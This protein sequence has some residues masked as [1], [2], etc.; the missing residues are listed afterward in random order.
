MRSPSSIRERA[1]L[2]LALAGCAAP[3]EPDVITLEQPLVARL[4][5][6]SWQALPDRPREP[7]PPPR[8]EVIEPAPDEDRRA[9]PYEVVAHEFPAISSDG[10]QLVDVAFE[11]HDPYADD[12]MGRYLQ[13]IVLEPDRQ[14]VELV[15]DHSQERPWE[16]PSACEKG[17]ARTRRTVAR[18]NRELARTSWRTLSKLE[19]HDATD[20][21]AWSPEQEALR[22]E[23]ETE[24]L[25][26]PI[27]ERP[28]EMLF[29]DGELVFRVR[30]GEEFLRE[31]HPDW[32]NKNS[33]YCSELPVF[34]PVMIDRTSGTAL[35]RFGY[36]DL[37]SCV[38]SDE[39]RFA[40]IQLPAALLTAVDRRS[41]S[42]SD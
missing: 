42:S 12:G 30:D 10:A 16:D 20:I 35:L 39:Q 19:L 23:A 28:V 33:E 15:F 11:T 13:L 36:E 7:D 31:Q 8:L 38:C 4:S 3:P 37:V 40:R 9:C 18:I 21:R 29:D 26:L 24:L 6:P 5:F 34:A 17:L 2:L 14:R 25:R 22:V 41:S 1:L 32:I 27:A